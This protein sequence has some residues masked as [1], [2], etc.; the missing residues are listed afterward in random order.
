MSL[1]STSHLAFYF[2]SHIPTNMAEAQTCRHLDVRDFDGVR[3]CLSCGLAVIE[4]KPTVTLE[5]PPGSTYQHQ[6]LNH[7]FGQEIRLVELLPAEFD[8]ELRCNI[9][10]T[11]L[12]SREEH[13]Y[14]A[15]SYTWATENGDAEF[16]QTI[17]CGPRRLILPISQN[18]ANALRRVRRRGSKRTIWID[19]ICIDQSNLQE[20]NH[21]VAL[22]SIIYSKASQVLIYLGEADDISNVIFDHLLGQTLFPIYDADLQTFCSRRWFHRVWVIQEVAMARSALVM[23]GDKL[24]HWDR[25]SHGL[26]QVIEGREYK[27]PQ[28]ATPPALRIGT[29]YY[30][31][32]HSLLHLL[33]ATKSCA[34]TDPRDKI[35]ALLALASNLHQIPLQADYNKP[36][37]WVL[38]QVAAWLT[39]HHKDLRVLRHAY[40]VDRG[41]SSIYSQP[42]WVPYWEVAIDTMERLHFTSTDWK[43]APELIELVSESGLP[44]SHLTGP[45]NYPTDLAL[46]VTG[47]NLGSVWL[48]VATPDEQAAWHP[49][50]KAFDIFPF[51]CTR[52]GPLQTIDHTIPQCPHHVAV[53][54]HSDSSQQERRLEQDSNRAEFWASLRTR[55]RDVFSDYP[56]YPSAL[57]NDKSL[58]LFLFRIP[59]AFHVNELNSSS[60]A[61]ISEQPSD[62]KATQVPNDAKLS[63]SSCRQ[64]LPSQPSHLPFQYLDFDNE[65]L[66]HFVSTVENCGPEILNGEAEPPS[67]CVDWRGFAT[68]HSLGFGPPVMQKGDS[69]WRLGNEPQLY[70][71]RKAMEGHY[72]FVG[73]CYLYDALR[74]R[75]CCDKERNRVWETITIW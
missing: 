43:E 28:V 56:E 38:V 20:R 12:A 1:R 72:R 35:Y 66:D 16:T 25:F 52:D 9:I 48:F 65:G 31:R 60:K 13:E 51:Y 59:P 40:R 15:T 5:P 49:S 17:Q 54:Y 58:P 44:I 36:F 68:E 39:D 69:V 53:L 32:G 10:H 67:R 22:M 71:L 6:P 29:F 11:N 75:N 47:Q 57:S 46:K 26:A 61:T 19:M 23:A 37:E 74:K 30:H 34:S 18:C 45:L 7:T 41:I 3:C 4:S 70:I 21:Q 64:N 14:Q 63:C 24:L 50:R 62:K 2:V 55:T 8:N 33:M 42:T 73:P 27:I